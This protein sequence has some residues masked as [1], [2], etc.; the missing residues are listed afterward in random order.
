MAKH[1]SEAIG[2]RTV[3]TYEHA[4]ADKWMLDAANQV[5][6]NCERIVTQTGRQLECEVWRQEGSGYHR[7]AEVSLQKKYLSDT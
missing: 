3:G 2:F 7:Y 4:L 6:Q 5:K 1:L